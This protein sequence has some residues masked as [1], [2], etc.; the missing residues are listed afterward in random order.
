MDLIEFVVGGIQIN[1]V[2]FVDLLYRAELPFAIREMQERAEDFGPEEGPEELAGTYTS[3]ISDYYWP[4]RHF[5]G[6]PANEPMG[7]KEDDETMLLV[8]SGCSIPE[9]W[10]LLAKV[11][12]T[13][14]TVRWSEFRNS[15]SDWDLSSVGPFTFSR[16]QYEQALRRRKTPEDGS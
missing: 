13:D 3:L 15:H 2:Q 5:L 8:C 4:S 12:V 10:S 11:E 16:T 9:C 14:S 6:E 7:L 1:G